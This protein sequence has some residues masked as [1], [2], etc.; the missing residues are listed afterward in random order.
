MVGE[1][2]ITKIILIAD[3][4]EYHDY[5]IPLMLMTVF[6]PVESL[7]MT[8][9]D[10]V[11]SASGVPR[12]LVRFSITPCEESMFTWQSWAVE[13]TAADTQFSEQTLHL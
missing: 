1:F 7:L 11:S 6:C 4:H 8:V 12:C 2:F 9:S 10:G 5:T 3:L 13:G